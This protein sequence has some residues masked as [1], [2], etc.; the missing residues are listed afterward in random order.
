MNG[1]CNVLSDSQTTELNPWSWT[2]VSNV[3]WID[4]PVQ[5]GYSYDTINQG[6]VGLV[7]RKPTA[8]DISCSDCSSQINGTIFLDGQ[9]DDPEEVH[10]PW[11][12]TFSSQN[13]AQTANTTHNAAVTVYEFMQAWMDAFPAYKR[14]SIALWTQS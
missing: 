8:P 7:R 2:N 14:D 13:P 11:P 1:P 3:L 4:Q 9:P 10:L 12:S 5:I 6:K